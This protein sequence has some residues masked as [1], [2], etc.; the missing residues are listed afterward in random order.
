MVH[1]TYWIKYLSPFIGMLFSPVTILFL[2]T[3][4]SGPIVNSETDLVE[5]VTP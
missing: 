1:K 4:W 5:E 3:I 2:W